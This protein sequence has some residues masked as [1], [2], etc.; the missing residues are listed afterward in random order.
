[1]DKGQQAIELHRKYQ[2]KI[3]TTSKIEVKTREDLSLVYTPYVA[4]VCKAIEKDKALAKDL[5]LKGRTIAVVTDGSAVL[6]LG[7]IGP[8]AALPVM[9]GKA[10]LFKTFGGLDAFPICLSTQNTHEIINTVKAIAPTFAG[11]NLED[12]AAPRC[13]EIE[14]ALQEIGIPVMHDDQAGTAIVLLAGMI[15]AAKV[16]KK[17]FKNMTVV[18]SGAGAAGMAIARLLSCMFYDQKI[19]I[20]VKNVILVDSK[21]IIN[22]DRRDLDV[23]KRNMAYHTNKENISGTL[24]DALVGA[25]VFIGVSRGN[26]LTADD[27]KKMN[28][29][30]IVFAMANPTPEIMPDEAKKGGALIVASGRSDYANQVNNLLA[31]P[32]VFKGAL[33]ANAKRITGNMKLAASMAIANLVK[34]PTVDCII[35]SVFEPNLADIVAEQVANAA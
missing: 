10:M 3:E 29:N 27:I 34:E 26:L 35:P 14:D 22:S 7:N 33:K 6:G 31:F 5:T 11:I 18:I 19:C 15:N 25:D 21:G 1:M 9:E 20:P 2:G 4:E 16:T 32:G 17:S 13:F 30:P 8:E 28:P 23:I 24:K 12:I